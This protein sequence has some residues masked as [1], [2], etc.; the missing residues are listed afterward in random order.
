MSNDTPRTNQYRGR[1]ATYWH[2]GVSLFDHACQL[3]RELAEAIRQRDE[4]I[5]TR[6]GYKADSKKDMAFQTDVQTFRAY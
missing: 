4:A 1:W 2:N 5:R 6:E 3:E